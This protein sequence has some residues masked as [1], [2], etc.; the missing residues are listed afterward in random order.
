MA[1][2]STVCRGVSFSVTLSL[3]LAT[4]HLLRANLGLLVLRRGK[5]RARHHGR[6]DGGG[7]AE[8]GPREGT[9]DAGVHDGLSVAVSTLPRGPIEAVELG[10]ALYEV[11]GALG[12]E[13]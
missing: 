12:D 5:S 7:R 8:S 3:T 13:R 1:D 4:D 6:A 10:D 2:L 9:E 11:R